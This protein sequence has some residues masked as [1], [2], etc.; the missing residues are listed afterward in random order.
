MA[1]GSSRTSTKKSASTWKAEYLESVRLIERLH[2]QFLEITRL[3]LDRIG[4]RDINNV[5]ALLLYNIG[6]DELS[7]G[8]LTQRGHYLGSNVSY[9]L[10]KLV[11]CK[12]I[13]QEPSPYDRRSLRVKATARGLKLQDQLDKIF[14]RHAEELTDATFKGEDLTELERTLR[15]L[16]Q[17]WAAQIGPGAG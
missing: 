13:S 17:F 1:Q 3:E 5:Q 12:Y 9:N 14:Q 7:V 2:R 16:E 4:I 8:E 15:R 6:H 10:K 11:D